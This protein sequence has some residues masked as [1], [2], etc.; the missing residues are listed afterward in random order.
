MPCAFKALNIL[1]RVEPFTGAKR[2]LER[3]EN[4]GKTLREMLRLSEKRLAGERRR[5]AKLYG[6]K[7]HLNEQHFD[8]VIDST[9]LSPEE[10]FEKVIYEITPSFLVR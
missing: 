4:R 3:T 8:I 9:H 1:I 5:Y 10:V 6:I 2:Q 7:D